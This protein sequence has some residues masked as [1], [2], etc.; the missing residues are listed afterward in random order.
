MEHRHRQKCWMRWCLSEADRSDRH[1]RA[2]SLPAGESGAPLPLFL[3]AAAG[4][5]VGIMITQGALVRKE[6]GFRDAL[7]LMLWIGGVFVF[8]ARLNWSIN[9]RSILPLVPPVCILIARSM[10]NR[11]NQSIRPYVFAAVIAGTVTLMTMIA[12]DQFALANRFAASQLMK[13]R[14]GE[15]VWFT[16]HWGFQYF[17]QQQGAL[18][19]DDQHPVCRSGDLLVVPLNN[20]GAPPKGLRLKAVESLAVPASSF[21]S[22]ITGPMGADFY[23]SPGDRLPFISGPFPRKPM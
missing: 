7:F 11:P 2:S 19:L 6:S 22:L 8:A 17:M 1:W 14:T 15:R 21:L 3:L 20:Y 4:V 5:A 9:A 13:N 10:E 23:F 12:D 18:P 16:G